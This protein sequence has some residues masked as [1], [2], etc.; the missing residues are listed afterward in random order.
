MRCHK[1]PSAPLI[2]PNS[3]HHSVRLPPLLPGCAAKHPA[4]LQCPGPATPCP[5]RTHT[6]TRAQAKC[7]SGVFSKDAGSESYSCLGAG[8]EQGAQTGLT[9]HCYI[10]STMNYTLSHV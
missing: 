3:T 8:T 1:P 2:I 9:L 7:A 4:L 5:V 10:Y 6:H